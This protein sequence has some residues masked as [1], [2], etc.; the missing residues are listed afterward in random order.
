MTKNSSKLTIS[1]I[2]ARRERRLMNAVG[3]S[4]SFYREN[5]HRFVED[6]FDGITLRLFQ[7]ILLFMMN[8]SNFFIL[9]SSR[10]LG[11]TYLIAIFCCVRCILYPNSKIVIASSTRTQGNLVLLKIQDELMKKSA[12]LR[13]EIADKGKQKDIS[14]TANNGECY[15]KNGSWIKVVTM[16]DNARGNRANILFVDEFVQTD[17]HVIDTV[18][19]KF[20]S[21][22]REP[23]FLNKPE[24][25]NYPREQNKE[26][27]ASSAWYKSHWSYKKLQTYVKQM[28]APTYRKYFACCLP[29]QIAIL[30]HLLSRE[31]VEDQMSEDDF[32][33]LT[34]MMEMECM[35]YGDTEESFFRFDNITKRRILK[36]ALPQ[37]KDVMTGKEKVPALTRGERRVLSVDVALMASVKHK[38]DASSILIN[39]AIPNKNGGFVSNYLLLEPYE[40]LTTDELGMYIMR[41]FYLYNCTDLVLDTNGI[42][43]PV[44]DYICQDHYDPDTGVS[45]GA[46][47][48]VNPR[49]YMASRCKVRNARRCV[50]SI[51]AN[52]EFN[53]QI[54]TYLRNSI[55]V[56]KINL[57]IDQVDAKNTFM[58]NDAK[59]RKATSKEQID[60]LMPYVQTTLL[61]DELINLKT[62]VNGTKIKLK[63]RSGMRKDR[64]SSMAYNNYVI[65]RI[66]R[67]QRSRDDEDWRDFSLQFKKPVIRKF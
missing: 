62:E 55:D 2:K 25:A 14:A 44:F 22:E 24:Y 32:N 11:K 26:L 34:W 8:Y 61:I 38:N 35:F 33:E 5:P 17:K 40:G 6:Y 7:K 60:I 15:F 66:A 43:T 28:V 65:E 16:N 12:N 42:G 1:Q 48:T 53:N 29:Y 52:A 30:E 37:L 46:L 21:S 19:T 50:W 57:L 59:F 56:G 41:Y 20:L 64:Y 9:F 3:R 45:Y 36:N 31:R 47:T 23:A 10:G 58:E 13:Y 67:K 18:L 49:D 39:C 54:A 27:Y 4:A 51:K 63:E